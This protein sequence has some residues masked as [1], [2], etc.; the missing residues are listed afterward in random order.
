MSRYQSTQLGVTSTS[1]DLT[2]KDEGSLTNLMKI[3]EVTK[4]DEYNYW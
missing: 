3:R 2:D 1:R 4:K